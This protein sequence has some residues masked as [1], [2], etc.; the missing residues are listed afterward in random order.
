MDQFRTASVKALPKQFAPVWP[1][2]IATARNK[3]GILKRALYMCCTAYAISSQLE[4]LT[5]SKGADFVIQP[6]VAKCNTLL[7]KEQKALHELVLQS[8][9]HWEVEAEDCILCYEMDEEP[10]SKKQAATQRKLKAAEATKTMF[11]KLHAARKPKHS[12]LSLLEV[13]RDSSDNPKQIRDDQ[14][15]WRTISVPTEVVD[16]LLERN[17]K[18][19]GQAFGTP[20]TVPPL[21]THNTTGSIR[22]V[23]PAL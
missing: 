4:D 15:K 23:L 6:I 10:S 1:E 18:H 21:S 8:C 14:T 17:R 22:R 19:F 11:K 9:K 5:K 20:F 13:P 16:L 12:G 2:A 3:V 7:R